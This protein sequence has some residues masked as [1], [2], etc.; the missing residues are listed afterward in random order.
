LQDEK[1]YGPPARCF[2]PGVGFRAWKDKESVDVVICYKCRDFFAIARNAEGK[3]A[4]RSQL[5][6]FAKLP[7][8]QG[9]WEAFVQLAKTAFPDDAEI[10]KLDP[11]E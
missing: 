7:G 3:E 6:G 8:F 10:Q 9:N 1:S 2:S 11:K 5:A 4:A